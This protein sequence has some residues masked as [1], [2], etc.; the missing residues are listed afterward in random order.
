[1]K[2]FF[3]WIWKKWLNRRNRKLQEAEAKIKR[4]EEFEKL[5]RRFHE[6]KEELDRLTSDKSQE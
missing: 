6:R 1:M 2:K 5:R 4:H 3:Q